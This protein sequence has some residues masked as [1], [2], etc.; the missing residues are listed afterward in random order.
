MR[1]ADDLYGKTF[2][3][4]GVVEEHLKLDGNEWV[5]LRLPNNTTIEIN[6]KHCK[7]V[8]NEDR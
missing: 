7:E 1:Y 2:A 8:K 4:V 6:I 3:V 5:V